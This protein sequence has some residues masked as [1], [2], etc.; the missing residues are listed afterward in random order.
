MS[1]KRIIWGK[2]TNC[3][4]TCIAPD[5]LVVNKKIKD[6]FIKELKTQIV[7]IYGNNVMNNKEYGRIISDKHMNYLVSLLENTIVELVVKYFVIIVL[8]SMFI[9]TCNQN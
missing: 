1:A 3:G 8:I 2:F 4:Q 5:F 6:K 7:K 9:L